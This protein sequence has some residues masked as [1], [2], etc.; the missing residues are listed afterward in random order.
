MTSLNHSSPSVDHYHPTF[1]MKNPLFQLVYGACQPKLK[2][3]YSRDQIFQEDGGHVTLDWYI[4]N[5]W[6]ELPA[7]ADI[8][9]VIHGLTGGSEM[10]YIK[11]LLKDA[12]WDGYRGVCFNS[13]GISESMTSPMPFTGTTYEELHSALD[14]IQYL[15]PKANIYLVGASFGG[16]YL[17]RYLLRQPYPTSIKGVVCLAPPFNVNK[18][19]EHMKPV[20]QKFFVKRY[21]KYTL[22][23]HPI[24]MEW[25]KNKVISL[26]KV[27]NSKNLF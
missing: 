11:Y 6:E 16:N 12:R 21:I 19:V 15:Y 2:L 5:K 18:V 26:N 24:M 7:N 1:Y 17:L 10:N 20:Y 4:D 27:Y 25:E 14:R 8:C 23:R 3:K 22:E 13:R 9:L